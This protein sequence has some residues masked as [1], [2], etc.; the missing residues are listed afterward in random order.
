MVPL[1]VDVEPRHIEIEAGQCA[2]QRF[3]L[4]RPKEPMELLFKG[5]QIFDGLV[6]GALLTQ[7]VLEL[8]HSMGIAGQEV[9]TLQ[10]LQR[11]SPLA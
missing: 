10:C 11:G 6:R 1:S 7:K 3:T 4:R 9:L 5:L 8:V 2:A